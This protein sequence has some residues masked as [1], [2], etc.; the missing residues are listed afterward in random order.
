MKAI[1][2]HSQGGPEVLQLEDVPTPALQSGDSLVRV[3]FAGVNYSDIYQ[4]SGLNP[5]ALPYTPGADAAG[6]VET[7]GGRLKAGT[8]VAWAGSPGS[9]AQ[10]AAVPSWKLV[11]LPDGVDD[12]HG[13]AALLQGMTAQYL[14]ESTYVVK[15]GE[16]ALVHAGAGGVGLLL[17]QLLKSKGVTVLATVSTA[18]KAQLA[19]EAGADH[20]IL[21][22]EVDFVEAA[23]A[24]TGG[25]G[26]HVVYDSVGKSTSAKSLSLLRPHG[27]L[28]LY[29]QSSGKAPPVDP[30]DLTKQGS[31]Y[32]VRPMLAHYIAD[33]AS[34]AERAGRVLRWI[35]E[36]L[37]RLRIQASYPLA[38][39][40]QA[41]R[42]L[43]S[44]A[45]TGKL[46]I[47]I[48]A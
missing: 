24:A 32:L 17:I 42:D 3:N 41:H 29:G 22:G 34:L 31:V 33:E 43:E 16:V 14:C 4:R 26:V 12:S 47:D 19:T 6:V 36:G 20:C 28:V 15:P 18:Q 35:E 40:A 46:L 37:L 30:L 1:R 44:R 8:R 11:A 48:A 39:A 38:Q 23:R 27:M 2:V 7:S 13:A 45:T 21:Y 9:Y 25:K 5:S 10:F